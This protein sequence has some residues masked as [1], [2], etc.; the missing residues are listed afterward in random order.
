MDYDLHSLPGQIRALDQGL[1][2]SILKEVNTIEYCC[3]GINFRMTN[4]L[5]SDPW[6][7]GSCN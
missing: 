1:I 3:C 4:Q 6:A 2:L 7:D 5:Y